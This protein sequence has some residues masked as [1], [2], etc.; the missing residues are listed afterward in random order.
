LTIK[1]EILHYVQDDKKEFRMTKGNIP[2]PITTWTIGS[3]MTQR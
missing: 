3:K 2:I 1:E